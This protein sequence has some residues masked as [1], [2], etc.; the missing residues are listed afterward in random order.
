MGTLIAFE[1]EG[2]GPAVV[3][4]HGAFAD[5][6][7]S[8]GLAGLL[9]ERFTVFRFDRRGRGNSGTTTHSVE[10]EVA[11]LAAIVAVAGGSA[12]AYGHSAGGAL[13]LEAAA[14]G[15]PLPRIAVYEPPYTVEPARL[16]D[17]AR[18]ADRLRALVAAGQRGDAVELFLRVAAQLPADVA[19]GWPRTRG[20]RSWPTCSCTTTR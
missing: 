16:A 6:S 11:D 15:V 3:L 4:A 17:S 18:L 9:A 20:G 19:P 5:R 10:L 2:R 12:F 7:A 14:R 13:V 8:A 1:R